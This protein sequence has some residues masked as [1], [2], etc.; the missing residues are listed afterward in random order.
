[1]DP[2]YVV[3]GLVVAVYALAESLKW[4]NGRK[5]GNGGF[6]GEDRQRLTTLFRQHQAMDG[7]GTPLWYV[8]RSLLASILAE[9]KSLNRTMGRLSCPYD[10]EEK[11]GG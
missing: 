4:R 5:N 8:P 11:R 3:G 1:M 10:K 2:T 9:L 7:D 6:T